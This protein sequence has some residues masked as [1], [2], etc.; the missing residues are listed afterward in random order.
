MHSARF[1]AFV[2]VA[3]AAAQPAAA[4]E[5]TTQ[6][7][8]QTAVTQDEI[9]LQG[10][11]TPRR[12]L[13][14]NFGDTG[15]WFVPTAEVLPASRPSVSGYRANF[16]R[17]QGLTDVSELGVTGAW[18]LGDRVELFGS[19]R[20][21]RADQ[22]GVYFVG[23]ILGMTLPGLLYVTFIPAGTDIRG[24]G[25]AAALANAMA[26]QAGPL[27]G[28]MIAMMGVWI[29]FKTQLDLLEG[30][31]RAI[32]DILWSGSHRLRAWRGGDVRVVYYSVL[33]VVVTWG[34]IA[35]RLSPP[36]ILL[37]LSANMAGIVFIIAS[38]H[39]LYLNTTLL[40]VELR[41]P[42][43]RRVALVAMALFYGLFAALW[44]WSM[45]RGGAA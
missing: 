17:R 26:S 10:D 8:S 13:P 31:V 41:P 4:Q 43:W 34:I 2:V 11:A 37:Q 33:G 32:T 25:V 14:T 30:M 18:G 20:I 44:V 39:L 28:G 40:P 42:L 3:A 29:L 16:D 5:P 15:L 19:W 22:W 24:L 23:V 45:L 6:T 1:V 35:L 9:V 12:A 21:V 38:L 7:T 27:F 36:I